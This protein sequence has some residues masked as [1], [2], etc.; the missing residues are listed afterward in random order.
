MTKLSRKRVAARTEESPHAPS[1][2]DHWFAEQVARGLEN[3][4]RGR[5]APHE[6][7]VEDSHRQRERLLAAAAA[8]AAKR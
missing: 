7:V 8:R 6:T 2:F 1:A 3:A 4:D 5:V